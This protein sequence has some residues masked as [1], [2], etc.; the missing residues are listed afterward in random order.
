MEPEMTDVTEK[1]RRDGRP[2]VLFVS[3]TADQTGPT[4]SLRHLLNYLPDRFGVGVVSSGHGLFSE[5]LAEKGIP[6]FSLPSMTKRQIPALARLIR[7][8]GFDLVYGNNTGSCSKNAFVASRL[9]GVPFI[10]HLRGMALSRGWWKLW[11]LRFCEAAVA[12]SEATAEVHVEYAG[13]RPRVV[14]N[15]VDVEPWSLDRE[16]A[17]RR[18]LGV[19]GFPEDATV[20]IGVAHL[21]PRKGQAMA[22]R[23][24]ARIADSHPSAHLALVGALDRDPAYVAGIRDLVAEAGLESRVAVTGF[25]ADVPPLVAGADAFVH[26]AVAD[27]HPRAVLEAMT[28]SLPVVAFAVDGVAETVLDG[29]TGLLVPENDVAALADAMARVVAS[30]ELRQRLGRKG[31][32]RLEAHFRAEDTARNVGDIIAEVLATRAENR[33]QMTEVGEAEDGEPG[34]RVGPGGPSAVPETGTA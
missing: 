15:G 6:Y 21:N 17:R 8:E 20:L 7:D 29:E 11:F 4:N 34:A 30:D 24:L 10:C 14:Y 5:W 19:T 16:A 12:V 18:L 26:T 31:R 28:A 1:G 25:Q 32:R 22:V 9:A 3:Y 2:R 23:A 33:P 13:E 27:P